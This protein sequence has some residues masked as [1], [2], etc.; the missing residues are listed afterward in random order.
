MAVV[1]VSVVVALSL[2]LVPLVS[3]FVGNAPRLIRVTIGAIL[4]VVLLNYVVMPRVTRLLAFWL[5][6]SAQLKRAPSPLP[7]ST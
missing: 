4:Q 5:F 1:L 2:V 7:P 3:H 6:P